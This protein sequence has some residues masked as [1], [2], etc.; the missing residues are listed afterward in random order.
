M[1]S[2]V[3]RTA[4]DAYAPRLGAL[5]I[6][7]TGALWAAAGIYVLVGYWRR[8]P[9]APTALLASA[10]LYAAWIWA[11][12]VMAQAQTMSNWPF[13]LAVTIVLL[14]FIT[15]VAV[16]RRNRRYFGKEAHERERQNPPLA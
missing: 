16:D 6:G 10:N 14:G 13:D 2:F 5:Y 15:A 4:L 11:D 1:T 8:S 12:K 9:W 3:W 7:L